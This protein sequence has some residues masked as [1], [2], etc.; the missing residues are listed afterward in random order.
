MKIRLAVILPDDLA[1]VMRLTGDLRTA[2]N[3]GD[4]DGVDVA[5]EKLMAVTAKMSSV[6]ITEEEWC[7]FLAKVRDRNA[8]FQSDYLVPGELC[9]QFFSEAMADTMVLQLPFAEREGDDV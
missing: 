5:T 2:V 4:M 6:D 9:S 1:R 3:S 8:A 7:R